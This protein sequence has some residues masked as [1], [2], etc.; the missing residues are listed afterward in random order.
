MKNQKVNC[1]LSLITIICVFLL[2]GKALA[3]VTGRCDNCHT[4]HNLQG[5]EIVDP[6]GPNPNLIKTDCIGCHS[7]SDQQ[8]IYQI[9]GCNVPVVYNSGGVVYNQTLAGGNFY[10]VTLDDTKGHNIF[11]PDGNLDRAPGVSSGSGCGQDGCHDNLDRPATAGNNR[12]GC[13]GCHMVSNS[14]NASGF[15]HADDNDPLDLLIDSPEEGWYRFLSGHQSGEG[16]GASGIEDTDWEQTVDADDHNEYLA[17]SGTKTSP[18]NFSALDSTVT[19]FCCGCHGNFHVEQDYTGAWIRHPSDAVIPITGEYAG[20]ITYNPLAPVGRP[21]LN[22]WTGPS[23]LVNE[24]GTEEKDMV[25]CLSCHRAHG[26]PY[27]DILRWDYSDRATSGCC[28]C[29]TSKN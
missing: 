16:H 26:S 21:S 12:K 5:G 8:T 15:H 25:I 28:I 19:A 23:S 2:N 1:Y 11:S 14:W 9:G 10:W 20:Y 3:K 27:P 17:L 13:L 24:G 4:M 18:G 22:G 6:G 7:R 29:H